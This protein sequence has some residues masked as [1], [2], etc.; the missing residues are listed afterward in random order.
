MK[1][2]IDV[3]T[4]EELDTVSLEAFIKQEKPALGRLLAYEQFGA[5][6]SN[7]TYALT[8]EAGSMYYVAHHSVLL[9]QKP[10]IWRENI[11][12]YP[13]YSRI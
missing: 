4:G 7:L 5:G 11:R 9:H 10:M 8:F 6:A 1:D 3:R 13:C 12:F 2:T